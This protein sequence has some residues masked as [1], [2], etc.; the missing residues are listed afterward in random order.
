MKIYFGRLPDVIKPRMIDAEFL[1]ILAYK[2]Y[3]MN[4][5]VDHLISELLLDTDHEV[6]YTINPLI[7]N[8]VTD[9]FAKEYMYFVDE[10]G[11]HIKVG[12]DADMLV[13]FAWGGV[14]EIMCDDA[15]VLN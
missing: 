11:N 6:A 7:I 1:G 15:R 14:G 13:K 10:N 4:D 8:F 9:E 3:N 12:D 5:A 2:R